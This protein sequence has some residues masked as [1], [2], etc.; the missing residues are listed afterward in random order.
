MLGQTHDDALDAGPRK[1]A[2]GT[3]RFCAATGEVKPVDEM[4]RFVVGP[5]GAAVPD[6]KRRLP[7]RGIWITATRQ[8]L[9]SAI[10]RKAFA[11]SFKRDVRVVADLVETTERLIEQ[12]ALDS[13]AMSRKAGAVAIGFAKVDVALA[14]DRVAGLINAAEAAPDGTRKLV[15]SLHR[16]EDAADIVVIDA[17]TSAQLDL[18]LGRANVIHAALLAGPESKTFLARTARLAR[19]RTGTRTGPMTGLMSGSPETGKSRTSKSAQVGMRFARKSAQADA[20]STRKSAQADVRST[21]KSAQA[22]V[23]YA[24][25][26][27]HGEKPGNGPS[28][29]DRNG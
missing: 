12:S 8:A 26:T 1:S 23:R 25:M 6:L 7:G 5:D 3:E 19:F 21:R 20:R 16:R 15:A 11:R 27:K 28:D 17:F 2:P 13:L 22:D 14:R 4:I 10:A 29:R 18:A 24:K 9:T